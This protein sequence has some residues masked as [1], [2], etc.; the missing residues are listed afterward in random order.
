M[1]P[2][3]DER[4]AGKMRMHMIVTL[5]ARLSQLLCE[6]KL[7][8]VVRDFKSHIAF[9][10]KRVERWGEHR[11]GD[12]AINDALVAPRPIGELRLRAYPGDRQPALV[13]VFYA[14]A[15]VFSADGRCLQL[16][17]VFLN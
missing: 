2:N 12:A 6:T 9:C 3:D 17:H 11:C 5:W 15:K 1:S 7:D 4:K 14:I 13:R 10:E 8:T 16:D